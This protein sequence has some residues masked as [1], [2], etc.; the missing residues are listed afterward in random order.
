MWGKAVY[1][2]K[3]ASDSNSFAFQTTGSR[4][5]FLGEVI[6]GDCV[7]KLSPEKLIKPPIKPNGFEYDS[8]QWV[9][10]NSDVFIVYA[11]QKCYPRYLVTF[12]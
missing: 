5:M 12:Q 11:N 10:G 6:L 8:V 1:F 9:T 4:Q 3:N 7:K 2:A